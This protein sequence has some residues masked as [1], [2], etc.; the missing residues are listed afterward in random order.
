MTDKNVLVSASGEVIKSEKGYLAI[1]VSIKYCM[2]AL[3][4]LVCCKY[5]HIYR[6]QVVKYKIYGQNIYII[7]PTNKLKNLDFL[8]LDE[9]LIILLYDLKYKFIFYVW[10]DN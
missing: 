5:I 1:Y 2:L 10:I 3:D 9:P 7:H 6:L 8:H 4:V